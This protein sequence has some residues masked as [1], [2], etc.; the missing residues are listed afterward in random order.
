MKKICNTASR[1]K[2]RE[3]V[4]AQSK[5]LGQSSSKFSKSEQ[6]IRYLLSVVA[7]GNFTIRKQILK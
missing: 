6:K 5:S 3:I 2:I 7:L 4:Q 1:P